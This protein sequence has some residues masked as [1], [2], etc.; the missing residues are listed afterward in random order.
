VVADSNSTD[1]TA[2]IGRKL[3]EDPGVRY[4]YVPRT[5]KGAAIKRAWLSLEDDFRV[6]AFM[7]V[8]LSTGLDAIPDL[9]RAIG[10]G[11]DLAVG[12]RYV[13]GSRIRRSLGR[14]TISR[15]YRI[16]FGLTFGYGLTDPQCG[17]KAVSPYAK[18]NLVPQVESE[19]FFF[20]T[21]LLVRAAAA[22]HSI[23]EIPINW[24][25]YPGSSVRLLRDIPE[26]L[27]GLATLKYR[28]MRGG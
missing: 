20:D 10:A 18:D 14:E 8:D 16:V 17:F 3:A 7:D 9:A 21:E 4:V 24:I 2:G 23:R 6:F 25:E 22:G 11:A 12:S 28:L 1:G 13:E 27:T 15:A 19:G 5:G 26:F